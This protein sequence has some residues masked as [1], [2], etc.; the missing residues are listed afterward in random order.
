MKNNIIHKKIF[1]KN[2]VSEE[3]V[4][5]GRLYYLDALRSFLLLLVVLM[6][7][8]QVYN[9]EQTWLIYSHSNSI[10]ID[11]FVSFLGLLRMPTF[12]MIAGYFTVISFRHS[13]NKGFLLKRIL[14]LFIPL[15]TI[16]VTLNILQAYILVKSG[17]KDYAL[18]TYII[19]GDWIQHLWF[20]IN[21]I[22]YTILAYLFIRFF[23]EPTKKVLQVIS[24]KMANMSLYTLLLVLPFISIS[25]I[26]ILKLTPNYLYSININQVIV[27]M[28]YYFFGILIMLNKTLLNKFAN[29]SIPIGLFITLF[30]FVLIKN[31][32]GMVAIQYKLLYYYFK[33]L[34]VWTIA[35][36]A[37]TIFKKYVNFKSDLIYK[38]SDASYSIYL[39]HH[40][41]VVMI[42]LILIQLNF[43]FL[44]GLPLLFVISVVLSYLVHRKIILKSTILK[45]L[46]NGKK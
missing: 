33:G 30:S 4:D 40:V 13:H 19:N 23:K 16:A 12:F 7:S 32:D 26:L 18:Q 28:P 25:V 24:K 6:H 22:I 43:S 8:S 2:R 46:I 27:Y 45:F 9:S 37:F 11:Y 29:I 21:L 17:W 5:S 39:V 42:G 41:I 36:L 14:R 1:S 34:A 31:V 38:I 15:I 20:L 3:L 44:I 10:I 35:S